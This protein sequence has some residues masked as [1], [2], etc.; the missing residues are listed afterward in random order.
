MLFKY[1]GIDWLIFSILI[2]HCWMLGNKMRSAFLLGIIAS[3]FGVCLGYLCGSLAVI[4]MN[5]TFVCLN[6]CNWRK[7]KALPSFSENVTRDS[8]DNHV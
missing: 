1:Y 5:S 2:V 6:F 4:L 3:C 8:G 7:W